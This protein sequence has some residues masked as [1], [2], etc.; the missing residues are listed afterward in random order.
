MSI[1]ITEKECD[2]EFYYINRHPYS[3]LRCQ[4]CN[5]IITSY[6]YWT[7]KSDKNRKF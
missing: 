7:I 3:D 4:K 2:H 5:K 6:D 1:Q